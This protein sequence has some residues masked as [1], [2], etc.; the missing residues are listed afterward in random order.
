M[1]ARLLLQ[2]G[3]PAPGTR[4]DVLPSTLSV[5]VLDYVAEG[6]GAVSLNL[7]EGGER[8]DA[9]FSVDLKDAV[10]RRQ[11]E[12][13]AF[14][15]Q[16]QLKLEGQIRDMTFDG[17]AENLALSLQIPAAKVTDMSVYNQ[18]LPGNSPLQLL[19]GEADLV[20][21]IE[22]QPETARGYVTLKTEK[23]RSRLDEQEISGDVTANINI[24]GGTPKNMAFDI[25]GST[26]L[27]D[28]IRVTGNQENLAESDW[29]ARVSFT[30]ANTVWKKPVLL[31]AEADIEM[32]DSTPIVAMLSN[33]RNKNGWIEEM[34]TVGKIEGTASMDMQQQQI[35]FPRAFAGSDKI[36]IGAKGVITEQSRDGVIFARYRKLKGLLKIRDGKRSFDLI[37]AQEKFED[38]SPVLIK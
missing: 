18:Y 24:A 1:Q 4:L 35:V 10:F 6:E 36:D 34:L 13:K 38:Y 5:S 26:L 33:H 22:L 20:A 23:L 14:I 9:H 16:V 17:P 29:H 11:H 7:E 3:W 31:K 19:G 12:E 27:L 32:K 15:E 37:K 8:P 28:N 30:R 21:D 2:G 25:T